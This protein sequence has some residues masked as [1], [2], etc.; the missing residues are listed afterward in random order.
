MMGRLGLTIEQATGADLGIGMR[1]ACRSCLMCPHGAECEAW[2]SASEHACLADAPV[3][4]PNAA[5]FRR[6]RRQIGEA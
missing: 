4:C 6:V 3:F 1:S 5:F 2:L